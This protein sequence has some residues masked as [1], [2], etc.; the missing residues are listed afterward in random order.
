[1]FVDLDFYS[2]IKL[3]N[4]IREQVKA[5]NLKPDVSASALFEDNKYLHP[6]LEDDA[7]LFSLDDLPS[8]HPEESNGI[9]RGTAADD[10]EGNAARKIAELELQLESVK[11]QFSEYRLQ[12]EETLEKR[13]NDA[14]GTSK[15][16]A[17]ASAGTTSESKPDGIDFEGDYFESYS[18][19]GTTFLT[20]L[21]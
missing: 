15:S 3:V 5:G 2:S 13:W 16:K 6:A 9:D 12:V 17:S 8:S 1:M 18:Y 4:Y 21:P 7:L 20:Y 11:S 19:N 10:S 14:E